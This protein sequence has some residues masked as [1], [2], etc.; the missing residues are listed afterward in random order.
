MEW[1]TRTTLPDSNS[2]SSILSRLDNLVSV[3]NTTDFDDRF[4]RKHEGRVLLD[5]IVLYGSLL[6]IVWLFFCWVRLQ[7]PRPYTLRKWSIKAG[8]KVRR[9]R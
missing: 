1:E 6:L 4:S 8:L 7:F 3:K 5:T 2:S 9:G